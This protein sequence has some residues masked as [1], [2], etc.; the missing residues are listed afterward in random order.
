VPA[1]GDHGAAAV[2][3]RHPARRTRNVTLPRRRFDALRLPL[4]GRCCAGRRRR[5]AG[6]RPAPSRRWSRT[7]SSARDESMNL[8]GVLPWTGWRGLTVVALLAAGNAFCFACP[9]MLP[10]AIARASRRRP[11][12]CRGGCGRSGRGPACWSSGP[13]RRSVSGMSAGDGVS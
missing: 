7:A 3:A 4:L 5:V 6:G 13:P 2:A 10:R 8:A 11:A 9:F 12:G 1:G